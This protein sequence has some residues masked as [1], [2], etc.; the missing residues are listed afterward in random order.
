MAYL[1]RV[2]VAA[3]LFLWGTGLVQADQLS[4][5]KARGKLICGTIGTI[6]P[7]SFQDPKTRETVGYEIDL[8]QSIAKSIGVGLEVKL[9]A[10]EARIPELT[11]GRVD[12]LSAAMGYSDERAKQ[13][14]YSLTTFV[15]RQMLMVKAGSGIAK[16]DDL[17]DKKISAPKGSSSEKYVR[18]LLPEAN[19]LTFQDPPSAFLALQQSKVS[20]LVLSELGLMKFKQ[21]AGEGLEL[22]AQPV[23]IEFWGICVHKDEPALLAA[24]NE[25]LKRLETSGEG[26][27]MFEKWFGKDTPYKLTRSFKLDQ[28]VGNPVLAP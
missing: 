2:I 21:Q 18:T 13:I 24:V 28:P 4:D 8:C 12:V 10:V 17:K 27:A 19:V 5:I 11:Q 3:A 16:I 26:A 23:A 15:S 1:N 7:F 9:L 20:A 14:D 22:V 25:T 6:E